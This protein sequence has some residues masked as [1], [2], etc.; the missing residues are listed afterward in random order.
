MS[1]REP[2]I[3]IIMPNYNGGRWIGQAIASVVEQS[4]KNWELI[5]IDDGSTDDSVQIAKKWQEKVLIAGE[6]Y[7][8]ILQYDHVGSAPFMR[9]RGLPWIYG[10]YI[11]F[12]DSDDWWIH[13][14]LEKQ[15]KYMQQ[16]D[17]FGLTYHDMGIED[18]GLQFKIWSDRNKACQGNCF[19][20]LLYKNFIPTSSVMIKS[21][22]ICIQDP[23]LKISHD[24]NMWLD[25]AEKTEIGFLP[26]VRARLRMHEGSVTTDFS[27]RRKES[28]EVIRRRK[29]KVSRYWYWKCLSRY[30]LA[31]IWESFGAGLRLG[32]I[33]G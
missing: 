22:F 17:K 15:L 8:R 13:L 32:E 27:Q 14:K 29:G 25:I 1:D 5:I 7:I 9:N 19:K 2:L 18:S 30:Y 10:G 16:N 31:E 3:S 33:Y 21:D 20:Q 28:R 26:E 23:S 12:L 24:W 11:A 4:Y 6:G